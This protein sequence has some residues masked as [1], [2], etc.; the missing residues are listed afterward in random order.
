MVKLGCEVLADD[1]PSWLRTCRLGLLSNQAS[2]NRSFENVHRIIER[3]GGRIEYLFSPQH[4][5]FA[6]KQANMKESTDGWNSRL[7]VPLISLYSDKRQPE[8]ELL[9]K[10]DALLVDLQDVGTRVYTYTTTMG[11][12]MEAAA[13][14]GTK[15]VILD[16]PNPINGAQ[17]EGN[18]LN[19]GYRS[20]V[21]RYSVP[22]RH[23]LT[24]GEFARYLVQHCN[25]SC[26]LE[27]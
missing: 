25:I 20:F 12:C 15:V 23:G 24:A 1:P 18:M 5:F 3:L 27:V 10:I 9:E 22:M 14:A 17:I 2:V 6:E 21:G 16:R 26:D 19:D 13:E 11:L 4:G 7:Q 8:V